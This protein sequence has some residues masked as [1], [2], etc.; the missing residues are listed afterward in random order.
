MPVEKRHLKDRRQRPTKPISRYAFV[1]RRKRARRTSELDNYYVD[2]YER[3]LLLLIGL[4][5]I[6]CVLDVIFTLKIN[7]LGG[8]EWNRFMLFLMEKNLAISLAVKFLITSVCSVFLLLHKNFRVFGIMK[9]HTAIYVIFSVYLIL[10]LY[11]FYTLV[12]LSWI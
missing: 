12:L 8:L 5:L 1:G 3:H 9:T 7:Q 6:F 2:K 10:I 11:E 4:I